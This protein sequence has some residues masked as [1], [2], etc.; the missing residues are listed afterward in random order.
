MRSLLLGAVTAAADVI[1]SSAK[2][3]AWKRREAAR[4]QAASQMAQTALGPVEYATVGE[5]PAVLVIHGA[6]GGYDQGMVAARLMDGHGLRLIAPSRPGYL[7]TPLSVGDTPARQADALAA[8]LDALQIRT[9]AVAGISAG[10]PTA[11]QFA[12]RHPARCRGLVMMAAVSRRANFLPRLETPACQLAFC[13]PLMNAVP[14]LVA[15]WPVLLPPML[16]ANDPKLRTELIRDPD[17]FES[18]LSFIRCGRMM[19]SRKAGI[20]ND[21][22][23]IARLPELPLESV[24]V[25]TLALHG[26]ADTVVSFDHAEHVAARVPGARLLPIVGGEHLFF[27]SHPEVYL[28]PLLDFLQSL[29]GTSH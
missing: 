24:A 20:R 23:Q 18:I 25:P 9:A 13:E 17:K 3:Q 2:Y 19:E 14:Y 27:A 11:L 1:G 6:S 21:V 12:L 26:T 7:R 5:G 8:L 16:S 4:L 22:A 10:G 28:P 29:P 15:R